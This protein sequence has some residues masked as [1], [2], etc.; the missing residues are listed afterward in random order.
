M[1]CRNIAVLMTAVDSQSQADELR[2]IEEY[3]KHHGCNL[4]VFL[5]FTGAFEKEKHNLGEVNIVN[6]PDLKLFDGVII[7]GNIFHI[8]ENRKMIEEILEE[9]TCPIVGIG[10]KVGDS[11]TIRTDN[12][13][14][15]R[16][17][18]EHF[19]LDHK[20]KDIHFVKGV[21]GNEDAND[22][23]RAYED[24]LR[25]NGIPI[26]QERTS[27]G[28]FYVTG[29]EKAAAEIMDS[30]LPF[31]QAIICAN[32]V[33]AITICDILMDKGYRIPED[34]MV[35]GYD[36]TVEAQAHSPRIT[37]I[38]TN[39]HNIG[40]YACKILLEALNGEIVPKDTFVPD[41]IVLDESCGCQQKEKQEEKE[42]ARKE[43]G[44]A[45][46]KR[47]MIH[48][49]ILLEKRFAECEILDDWLDAVRAF[50]P[51]VDVS[52]FYCCVNDG[53]VDKMFEMDIMEQEEMTMSQRLSFSNTV[54][55]ILAYKDGDFKTKNAFSSK[56][57]FDEL[58]KDCDECKMY[59]FSPLHYLERTFG[60]LVFADSDFTMA[61]QLYISWLISMGNSIENIRKKSMLKN[62][63]R[64]LEDMYVRDPLTGV[65]NR[66]GLDRGFAE[67]K[68]K[69][70]MSRIKMQLSFID[71]DNLKAIN[72]HYGHE[73]GD[74][75]ITAAA[76]ILQEEAGKC[77]VARYGGDEF[78][79]IGTARD[80]KEA[81]EYWERVERRIKEY[82]KNRD[83]AK[84]SMSFG[85]DV[86][87]VE[88]KTTLE[89]C[90]LTVDKKMYDEKYKKKEQKR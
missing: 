76:R 87:N 27:Q 10:C 79:V 73:M 25:E 13:S 66:F 45:I 81:Q 58:F 78:I 38:R 54:S 6:L 9:L 60:Y 24:V 46:S 8:E 71:L 40:C 17:M 55:P 32:D 68:Q 72:D 39:F 53:F 77:R 88:G 30:I 41:E 59:I 50:I 51:K 84:L 21:E 42:D 49:L 33:M 52:E 15:M 63:M 29:G 5:W 44:E 36:Y 86:F 75:I 69:S 70:M 14:A 82:N 74:E 57:A 26:L 35:S 19:V 85:Y 65:Y 4:A 34:V 2:G 23:Y 67:I 7:F 61:N 56:Y 37:S 18:V 12:Y 64:R 16:K 28:D 22:R 48:Q 80:V 89:E 31:P 47:K 20:V 11:Y 3:A 43:Y 1:R 90:I 83:T 62:A